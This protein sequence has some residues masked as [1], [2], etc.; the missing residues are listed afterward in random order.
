MRKGRGMVH[1][2]RQLVRG[3]LILALMGVGTPVQAQSVD[4]SAGAALRA[5]VDRAVVRFRA[6][7]AGGVRRPH[8]IFERELAFEARLVA[9][10]DPGH[11]RDAEPYRRHHLQAALERH[12]A[13]ALLAELTIEPEP[14]R[15][16]LAVQTER[17][18]V[19]GALEVGG[20]AV[21][22][23]AAA[24]EGLGRREIQKVFRRRARASFYLDRMVAPM[25]R[26]SL[27]ELGRVHSSVRNPYS[28]E[29]LERVLEPLRQW[30]VGQRL[31]EA[32]SSFYQ[33][34]RARL[35]VEFL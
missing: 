1:L 18:R 35:T 16:E 14:S 4:E 29:P 20:E 30:Y 6:P 3:L 23:E 19:L 21:L 24:A 10:T 27:L 8:F 33:N 15:E 28:G 11:P 13:E 34:A 25:L 5:S 9:R 17:A 26:P 32:L 22:L 7:E 12:I 2:S 31:R